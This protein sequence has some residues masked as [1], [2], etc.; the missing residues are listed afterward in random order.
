MSRPSDPHLEPEIPGQF[1]LGREYDLQRG[2]RLDR[3]VQYD[4]RDLTT[5]ALCVG[6]TGSGKTG[7]CM[8]L[9]EEAALDGIPAIVVDPKG[10]LG[11]LLLAFPNLLSSDF[12]PWIEPSDAERQQLSV[13]QYA[14]RVA[15]SWR[16]GL[17]QWGQDGARIARYREAVDMA[18]YTP[19]SSSGVP[20]T[21]LR[22]FAAPSAAILNDPDAFREQIATAVGGLLALLGI[23]ADPLSSPEHILLATILEQQWSRGQTLTLADLIGKIQS[24]GI[25]RVGVVD[26]ETFMPLADR[27]ALAMKLN[28]LL[29]SPTFAP[30]L[31]GEPLEIA[32][33]LRTPEGKPRLSILSI[34]HL[35]DSERMFFVTV[36]L[37]QLISWMRNQSG[38]SS[39]RAIF[40]MDEVFGYFPPI[41]MPPTKRA[42]LTLL[43][44][45]RAYG[46]GIV[47]ATQ[48]PVDLDYKGLANIGTWF[49]G[50]LQTDRDKQRMLDGLEGVITGQGASFDRAQL[51]RML[52]SLEK[53]VFLMNNVHERQPVV[54]QSRWALSYLH[55][56]LTRPQIAALMQARKTTHDQSAGQPA[57]PPAQPDDR[58]RAPRS[59]I[60]RARP[61]PPAEVTQRFLLPRDRLGSESTYTYYPYLLGKGSLHFVARKAKVDTW[62]E[63]FRACEGRAVTGDDLWAASEPLTSPVPLLSEP[64]GDWPFSDLPAALL[65]AGNYRRWLAEF[66]EYLY[67]NESLPIYYC[68]MLK[69]Y[70]PPGLDELQARL[71]LEPLA[72]EVRDLERDK[73]R[74]ALDRKL[75]QLRRRVQTAKDRLDREQSQYD[76]SKYDSI[77]VLSG[78]VL[79][80]VLGRRRKSFGRA[81]SSASRSAQQKADVARAELNLESLQFERQKLE[82]DSERLQQ[83]LDDDYDVYR[84]PLELQSLTPRKSD[85]RVEP[86]TLLW[87]PLPG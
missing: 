64:P 44:Q 1:Y 83:K 74:E 66:K 42:M 48:N 22:D 75:D 31:T 18:I 79:G 65:N 68:P 84:L 29:A 25:D 2:E 14:E 63:V 11:N 5:H 77:L 57:V 80:A 35:N 9:L 60:E 21:V 81:A 10:D 17:A 32:Q 52:S 8:A 61:L 87:I 41:S 15:K 34:A 62:V 20:L 45:A 56:P 24:P 7:L 30:W 49:L 19:G 76:A 36:L 67:R 28:S 3:S 59:T 55:G 82:A 38:T 33:L 43:K 86:L 73:V 69:Q 85:L 16:D 40:Y 4:A 26:L 23:T 53:R 47:L 72:R 13:D 37:N 39:L 12:A 58:P 50:R 46:L 51:D 6:M 27:K 71:A 78:T 70:A 54:F